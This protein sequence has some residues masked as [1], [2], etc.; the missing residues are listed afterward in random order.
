MTD[1]LLNNN[2][3]TH[4]ASTI[5]TKLTSCDVSIPSPASVEKKSMLLSRVSPSNSQLKAQIHQHSRNFIKP[6]LHNNISHHRHTLTFHSSMK[7]DSGG[8][9][10]ITSGLIGGSFINIG[11]TSFF[12]QR[13]SSTLISP[14]N[15]RISEYQIKMTPIQKYIQHKKSLSADFPQSYSPAIAP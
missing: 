3:V 8:D 13:P 14:S 5:T 15:R 10:P 9:R 4:G 11:S 1:Q 7:K 2:Q 6:P 12:N